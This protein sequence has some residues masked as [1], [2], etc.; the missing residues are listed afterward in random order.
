VL[1]RPPAAAERGVQAHDRLQARAPRLGCGEFGVERGCLLD[2]HLE[3]AG[4]PLV[5]A[6]LRE[7]EGGTR[8]HHLPVERFEPLA[9]GAHRGES[10]LH[11]AE[12]LL[13]RR[14]VLVDRLLRL[15]PRHLDAPLVLAEVEQRLQEARGD[16]PGAGAT[17][18]HLRQVGGGRSCRGGQRDQRE[19]LRL[20][21]A[22]AG[23]GGHQG[24]FGGRHV[25]AAPQQIGREAGRDLGRKHLVLE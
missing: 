13:H 9:R 24:R 11:F 6:R 10:V 5:V 19:A 14:F 17:V 21:D 16:A 8:R 7:P 1:R 22:D 12:G 18:C 15:R 23:V 25:R 20:G 4:H 3:I 2:E